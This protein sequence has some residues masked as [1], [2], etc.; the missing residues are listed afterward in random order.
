MMGHENCLG[1]LFYM[2]HLKILIFTFF[3]IL[4]IFNEVQPFILLLAYHVDHISSSQSTIF[5]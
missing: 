5:F 4:D 3:Y 1:L 2:A